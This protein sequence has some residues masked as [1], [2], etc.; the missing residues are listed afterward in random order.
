MWENAVECVGAQMTVWRMRIAG[1]INKATNARSEYALVIAFPKQQWLRERVSMLHVTCYR[2]FTMYI[3]YP[4]THLNSL[5][6]RSVLSRGVRPRVTAAPPCYVYSTLSP[7][8][9]SSNEF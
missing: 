2:Q 9:E 1:L 4:V 6:A 3:A 7:I 8:A 5:I